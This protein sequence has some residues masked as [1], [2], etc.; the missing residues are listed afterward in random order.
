MGINSLLKHLGPISETTSLRQLGG[1]TFA[2]DAY[3]WLH[4]SIFTCPEELCTN[5]PTKGYITYFRQRYEKLK[6]YNIQLYM[7]FDGYPLGAKMNTNLSRK[8]DRENNKVLAEQYILK[9]DSVKAREH[10]SRACP[11]TVHM[12]KSWIKFCIQNK[13]PYI[14]APFEADS[15]MVYLEKLGLV[16]GIISEDSDLLIFGCKTLV[17]KLDLNSSS[18]VMIERK[19][20]PLMDNDLDKKGNPKFPI[21][22]LS[23]TDLYNLVCLSGCD[24]TPGIYLIGLLKA[25][26]LLKEHDFNIENAIRGVQ[27]AYKQKLMKKKDAPN[28]VPDNYLEDVV[29]A[30]ICFEYMFVFDPIKEKVCTLNPLPDNPLLESE[31]FFE[32]MGPL[33]TKNSVRMTITHMDDIAHDIH[34][35]ISLGEIH[36][37]TLETLLDRESQLI[38]DYKTEI[39]DLKKKANGDSNASSIDETERSFLRSNSLTAYNTKELKFILPL[40]RSRTV[41]DG[42]DRKL[43]SMIESRKL[44]N[45][46]IPT[47]EKLASSDGITETSSKFFKRKRSFSKVE[48]IHPIFPTSKLEKANLNKK[49]TSDDPTKEESLEDNENNK[50]VSFNNP[51]HLMID[52]SEKKF[53]SHKE[54]EVE[55]APLSIS[56]NSYSEAIHNAT[57]NNKSAI[58]DKITKYSY[59]DDYS[60]EKSEMVK[61]TSNSKNM[62]SYSYDGL[63][64]GQLI[65]SP[66]KKVEE[67]KNLSAS[68]SPLKKKR[69]NDISKKEPT[70]KTNP[71][72]ATSDIK[73]EFSG[74]HLS[75]SYEPSPISDG[76]N[77]IGTLNKN[78]SN[79][80]QKYKY[81]EENAEASS[82]KFMSASSKN[83]SKKGNRTLARS[84]GKKLSKKET[85][86]EIQRLIFPENSLFVK[87]NEK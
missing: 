43:E 34:K 57:I 3:S 20:F 87:S 10:Y 55:D 26:K 24:Y 38:I 30:K 68:N 18:C 53:T 58:I 81:T 13:I 40:R 29:R 49:T 14:V 16:D 61:R 69:R 82:N 37:F 78:I 84:D 63:I 45:T 28:P 7:V 83:Y 4:K 6:Q 70:S 50:E 65:E 22:Q 9:G 27:T 47:S 52:F 31:N 12:A 17:T 77:S 73:E 79:L 67:V 19:N 46:S 66:E 39:A 51:N 86:D 5:K 54:E 80:L 15:Q 76:I 59:N 64:A 8:E 33:V 35:L 71:L 21:G 72:T 36:Q 56:F 2:V 11:V 1:K 60:Y 41:D 48:L 44:M 23:Q 75:T 32:Y 25:I 62:K 42:F 85:E 74:L